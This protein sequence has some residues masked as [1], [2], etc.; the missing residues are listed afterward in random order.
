MRIVG[1]Y[2]NDL[3]EQLAD[4]L[5]EDGV[6]RLRG[7]DHDGLDAVCEA[8]EEGADTFGVHR[9]FDEGLQGLLGVLQGI[10]LCK[11]HVIIII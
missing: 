10:S 5:F 7:H 9:Q 2:L 8:L 1:S 6:V 11:T 3:R 4:E